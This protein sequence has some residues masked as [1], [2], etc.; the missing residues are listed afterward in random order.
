MITSGIFSIFWNWLVNLPMDFKYNFI[1]CY[2]S[3]G[4][5]G[6][7]LSSILPIILIVACVQFVRHPE[8]YGCRS[9]K[10]W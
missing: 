3:L 4:L 2:H 8:K 7:I 10:F 5:F 1:R 9:N 6:A